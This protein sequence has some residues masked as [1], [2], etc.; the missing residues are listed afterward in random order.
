[1]LLLGVL[2]T[3]FGLLLSRSREVADLASS[4]FGSFVAVTGDAHQAKVAQDIFRQQVRYERSIQIREDMR[5]VNKLMM[6]S[7]QTHVIMGSIILGVCWNMCIEG[8]PPEESERTVVGLWLIFTCW[9]VTFTLI[10]LWL[11]LRFQMKMSSSARDRL[12]RRHR[13]MVPD[14]LV[15]GR[16]GGH[17]VVNHVA[18]FHSWMLSSINR[19]TATEPHVE[20]EIIRSKRRHHNLR[21]MVEPLDLTKPLDAEPLRKGMHA[22]LHSEE[23]NSWSHHTL[24]DIPFFLTGETL[25]RTHW[26]F[27][28]DR[29]MALRVYG[30]ST[31]YVAAQCPPLGTGKKEQKSNHGLR[32]ALWLAGQVPDWPADEL[33]QAFH[34]FHEDWRGESGYGE[35]RRVEGFSMYVD[36]N[37][38]EMPLY[39]L[40]LADPK[41]SDF[42]DVV[43]RW[44][45]KAGCEALVVVARKGQVHCKE[46]D[47][48][49]AEFNAEVK[50]VLN[51]RRYSGL[52]LRHGTSCLVLACC[53]LYVARMSVLL[54]NQRL[55]WYEAALVAIAMLPSI[56]AIGIMP[57]D[58]WEKE[59]LFSERQPGRNSRLDEV[60]V[61]TPKS[62]AGPG[63]PKSASLAASPKSSP[64]FLGDVSRASSGALQGP[65]RMLLDD[66]SVSGSPPRLQLPGVEHRQARNRQSWS[67]SAPPAVR[68]Q[69]MVRSL[70]N[71]CADI[72]IGGERCE[73]VGHERPEVTIRNLR[74]QV[75]P[76]PPSPPP[77]HEEHPMPPPETS[78]E[79]ALWSGGSPV[80]VQSTGAPHS[81]DG[82]P[83]VALPSAPSSMEPVWSDERALALIQIAKHSSQESEK[84]SWR[85]KFRCPKIGYG[86]GTVLGAR[87]LELLVA[88]SALAVLATSPVLFGFPE[89][90]PATPR[91]PWSKASLGA[92]PP[93]FQGTAALLGST[94]DLILAAGPVLRSFRM[95]EG[96]WSVMGEPLLLPQAVLGLAEWDGQLVALSSDGLRLLGSMTTSFGVMALPQRWQNPLELV[97]VQL[98]AATHAALPSRA[99]PPTTAAAAVVGNAMAV[100]LSGAA[101]LQLCRA[102]NGTALALSFISSLKP[103]GMLPPETTGL[104][105]S[106]GGSEPVV[107]WT[108]GKNRQLSAVGFDSGRVLATFQAAGDLPTEA[109]SAT[110]VT[111]NGSHLLLVTGGPSLAIFSTPYPA[112]DFR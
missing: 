87:F 15:V 49:L 91:L 1:M 37:D 82:S 84:P 5:D 6:E 83:V 106:A 76:P 28:G 9:A 11:A 101:G 13:L 46:E 8:F 3:V 89:A 55:W 18:N 16:M 112:L 93:L 56:V 99:S 102:A 62:S 54:Q 14:D 27:N 47:W 26:N 30:A 98:E 73:V 33:P 86:S 60:N 17:N 19:A 24:L 61:V 63:R 81:A 94:G 92:V 39:K 64:G 42:V 69:S 36:R 4:I 31:L 90:D 22:W 104:H 25:I 110:F 109:S 41:H 111:G 67:Q 38:I 57:L 51:L 85:R 78:H 108:V 96:R 95:V 59:T 7:V 43:I 34:G 70:Q 44:N 40:V 72:Q 74:Q 65:A 68:E 105:L 52:F 29:I 35:F 21:V 103:V 88:L 2:G 107:L 97:Q 79:A 20:E 100:V 77:F 32:K 75:P 48:P 71:C 80:A 53:A 58:V 23:E 50:E 10:A 45:F 66:S 12:L